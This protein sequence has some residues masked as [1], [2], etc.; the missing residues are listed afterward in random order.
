[1]PS[2][3]N[4]KVNVENKE[5]H[6]FKKLNNF[7]QDGGSTEPLNIPLTASKVD[8]LQMIIKYSLLESLSHS[9]VTKLFTLVNSI[10]GRDIFPKSRFLVD[11]MLHSSHKVT[12]HALCTKCGAY[13]GTF[14]EKVLFVSCSKC[15]LEV[16][17]RDPSYYDFF[18]T[19]S[20]SYQIHN[21]IRDHVD[22][23]NKVLNGSIR[24]PG[25][26]VDFFDGQEYRRLVQQLKEDGVNEYCTV[27][28][29]TDRAPVFE[30]S[31]FS[32]WPIQLIL[33]EIPPMKD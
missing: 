33:N 18:I 20:P 10:F 31:K 2:V 6:L 5:T 28:F 13:L 26:L 23:F 3:E 8:I 9:A 11:A 1:M 16:N 29:N 30:S 15:E 25:K 17:V 27:T 32:I 19:L 7:I 14:D 4:Y 24:V 12:Y 21:L 22:Y